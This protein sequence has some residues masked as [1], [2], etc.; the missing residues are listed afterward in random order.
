MKNIA[1]E[2]IIF[3]PDK[4]LAS[5]C[6]RFVDKELI[7]WDGYCYVHERMTK[8]EVL[9]A[10]EKLPDAP[11]LVHPECNPAVVD[12]ADEILSTSGIVNFAKKSDKKKISYRN[13]RRTH[14]S[15]KKGES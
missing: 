7:P 11:L 8:E 10:K 6:Q 5:Y 9:G 3:T 2:R 13:R 15:F 12:I 14:P 4:N 1:A